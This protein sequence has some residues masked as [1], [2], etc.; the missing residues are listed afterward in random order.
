MIDELPDLLESTQVFRRMVVETTYPEDVT[1]AYTDGTPAIMVRDTGSNTGLLMLATFC[2]DTSWTNLPT[3]P[4]I[5]PLVQELV[6]GS[7]GG[8]NNTKEHLT[9]EFFSTDIQNPTHMDFNPINTNSI[10]SI[11][12]NFNQSD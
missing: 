10:R 6:R 11:N 7:L 8:R 3:Q 12:Q 1:I 5:I 9:G 4:V 2:L